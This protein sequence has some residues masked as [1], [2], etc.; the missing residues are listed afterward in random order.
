[1]NDRDR[2]LAALRDGPVSSTD[3]LHPRDGGKPI[4][5]LAARK[6]DLE[7]LGYQ[8]RSDR[9][10]NGTA[11]YTLTSEPEPVPEPDLPPDP[12]P[13]ESEQA[14]LFDCRDYARTEHWRQVA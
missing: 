12:A 14:G 11:L 3:F 9:L 1:M 8:I 7:Q 4:L 6:Y 13:D 5:R 2:F 10:P